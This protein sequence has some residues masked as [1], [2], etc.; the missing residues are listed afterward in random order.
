[1]YSVTLVFQEQQAEKNK[2]TLKAFDDLERFNV[3]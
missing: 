3:L 2:Q 1:M